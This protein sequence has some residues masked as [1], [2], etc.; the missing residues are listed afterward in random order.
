[1][2][3]VRPHDVQQGGT[4]LHGTLEQWRTW[5]ARSKPLQGRH[6]V[7]EAS[8][9]ISCCACSLSAQSNSSSLHMKFTSPLFSCVRYHPY[10]LACH[11]LQACREAAAMPCTKLSRC[12]G[13]IIVMSPLSRRRMDGQAQSLLTL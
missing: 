13:Y 5:N 6:Q 11:T 9:T 8:K 12:G 3:A 2:L 7:S 4:A 1:M 10:H